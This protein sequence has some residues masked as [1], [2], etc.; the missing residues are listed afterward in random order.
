LK[1]LAIAMLTVV[2]ALALAACGGG[3]DGTTGGAAT[4]PSG[5]ASTATGTEAET[6]AK[7]PPGRAGDSGAQ[8]DDSGTRAKSKPQSRGRDL[9]ADTSASFA[10]PAHDDSPTGIAPFE[11]RGGDNSIQEFGAEGSGADFE[12]AATALHGYLDAR[13]AAAWTAACSYMSAAAA[14]SLSQLTGASGGEASCPEALATLS[15]GVPTAALEEAAEAEVGALR[16]EGDRAFLIFRG[17]READY[18][19]PM[20]RDGGAWKVAAIASSALL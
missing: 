9:P 10:A 18:F 20:V 8:T 7:P 19:M 11:A 1:T 4:A 6:T 16:T 5:T 2:V 17:A 14:T 15:A 13:A 12:A 3:G